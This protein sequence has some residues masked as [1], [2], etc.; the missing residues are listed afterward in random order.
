MRSPPGKTADPDDF[1]T[2][3][4]LL[5]DRSRIFLPSLRHEVR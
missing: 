4:S 2:H 3:R 1:Q 5:A